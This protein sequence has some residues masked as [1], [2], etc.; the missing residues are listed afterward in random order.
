MRKLSLLLIIILLILGGLYAAI[1]TYQPEAKPAAHHE[2]PADAN[3]FFA[4]DR[5]QVLFSDDCIE[6]TWH[7]Y[8][9]QQI[10]VNGYIRSVDGQEQW[11][12]VDPALHVTLNNGEL[13]T[14]TYEREVVVGWISRQATNRILVA[15]FVLAAAPLLY[16]LR[17]LWIP[18]IVSTWNALNI[19]W[20]RLIQVLRDDGWT[21]GVLL[22]LMLV[23]GTV[24]RVLHIDERIRYDEA[25]T[26]VNYARFSFSE[27]IQRYNE[28]NNHLFYTLQV[29]LVTQHI[30][31]EPWLMRI[32]ALLHGL[33]IIPT[34]YF[35]GR[36]MFNK[37]AGLI[38]AAVMTFH[39]ALVSYSVNAR[40][41]SLL[42]LFTVMLIPL[43]AWLLRSPRRN[44]LWASVIIC[45]ALGFYTIPIMLYP[46]GTICVWLGLGYLVGPRE[47]RMA[48][49]VR[50]IVSGLLTIVVVLL[51]YTPVFMYEGVEAVTSNPFVTS[52]GWEA[53]IEGLYDLAAF[54]WEQ[55]NRDFLPLI[56]WILLVGFGIA[57]VLHQRLSK[58]TIPLVL[59][60]ILWIT[61]VLLYQ[62]VFGV[63]TR[64]WLFLIPYYVLTAAG[65]VSWM[66]EKL[67]KA[68]QFVP[69][70][71]ALFI[72]AN[73]L[74]VLER[75]A[76]TNYEDNVQLVPEALEIVQ[77]VDQMEQS[78][79]TGS[80]IFRNEWSPEITFYAYYYGHPA[81]TIWW[82]LFPKLYVIQYPTDTLA[83]A[84][85]V[86]EVSADD[87][88]EPEYIRRIGRFNF[89]ISYH[90]YHEQ[91]MAQ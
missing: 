5:T 59:A 11:C 48:G 43:A 76:I 55:W 49:L 23:A 51:L 54:G 80:I 21:V 87:Y 14:I 30:G 56:T 83:N 90:K 24:L 70:I 18:G 44:S 69:V 58:Q 42:V 62:Q 33:L 38:A 22:L 75:D 64:V 72:V 47:N 46:F 82:P 4:T 89:Y 15:L 27:V 45:A 91:T 78:G 29:H 31:L 74:Y 77:L 50:L 10:I 84:L 34:T 7:I 12:G 39:P 61:P 1:N 57:L 32:P 6:L 3:I 53:F 79:E 16:I 13:Y 8:Q 19:F 9:T 63:G 88:T 65:G 17:P 40:G 35:A 25:F 28:P 81:T 2:F 52:P 36:V 20:Q 67:P 41:Y 37:H 86:R 71:V 68:S 73:S 26:Y 66:I 60:A 85:V